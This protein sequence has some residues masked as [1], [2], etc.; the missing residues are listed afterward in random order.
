MQEK[1]LKIGYL[2]LP[3]HSLNRALLLK[4]VVGCGALSWRRDPGSRI[5]KCDRGRLRKNWSSR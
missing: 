2:L 3:P 5:G 1:R 4:R